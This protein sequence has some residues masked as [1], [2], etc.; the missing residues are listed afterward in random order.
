MELDNVSS[1]EYSVHVG[2][3]SLASN[4]EANIEKKESIIQEDFWAVETSSCD[5]TADEPAEISCSSST[6]TQ[7]K[8]SNNAVSHVEGRKEFATM[9][10]EN[11][12]NAQNTCSKGILK[13]RSQQSSTGNVLEGPR[14]SAM[15][16]FHTVQLHGKVIIRSVR[17]FR[18]SEDELVDY[19][20]KHKLLG[21]DSRVHLI[22]VIDL[23]DVEP[24]DVPVMLARSHI[25]FGDPDWFFFSPV[26]FKYSNSKRVNR[27]TKCG[28]WKATGK[29]RD[30]RSWDTNTRIATKKTLVY[31]KG[32]VSSGVKSYWVIHE[33]HAV[34]FHESKR[35]FV[36]CRLMKK[37]RK[38]IEGGTNALICDEGE[39]SKLKVPDYENKATTEGISSGGT[40]TGVE[41]ISQ[42]TQQAETFISSI[43]Q[44]P[45]GI[46]QEEASFAN[47]P[48]DDAYFKNE[49]N[50]IQIPSE[51]TAE[52]EFL[53]SLLADENNIFTSIYNTTQP[54]LFKRIFY[55]D[56]DPDVTKDMSTQ[57]DNTG[58]IL[59]W[60]N[61]YSISHGYH[62][63]KRLKSSQ[64]VVDDICFSSSDWETNQEIK[65]SMLGDE[66]SGMESS[67]CDSTAD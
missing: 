56:S 25:R 53:N 28:F 46:E 52:D 8:V 23:C 29:D 43:Q 41:T 61:K 40:F 19:Y 58:D 55:E 63:S 12:K 39:P 67:Y 64:D 11:Q 3:S 59:G 66:F 9:K 54:K 18:P 22:P 62:S 7:R 10:S 36:L 35:T 4:H 44:S 5:S 30:I 45:A 48:I 34:T 27:K 32:S 15:I 60:S 2:M 6:Q 38:I 14:R 1:G 24:S 65:E 33:Y 26:D 47:Y 42:A 51:I 21:D 37:P 17:C 20:L 16:P 57:D 31:Y 49:D 50:F 13:I